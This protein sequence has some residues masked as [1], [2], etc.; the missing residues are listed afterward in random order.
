MPALYQSY[1]KPSEAHDVVVSATA[2]RDSGLLHAVDL[3]RAFDK[4][5]KL[6]QR[7]ISTYIVET[8]V[9]NPKP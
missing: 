6:T 2:I 4:T 1:M 7:V 3:H 5:D 9:L 8:R